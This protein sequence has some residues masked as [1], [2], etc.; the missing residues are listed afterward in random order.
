LFLICS[1]LQ[2]EGTKN[3]IREFHLSPPGK[4]GVSCDADGAFIGAMPIL[5]RLRKNGRDEWH[6]RDCQVLSKQIGAHYGLPIDMSSKAPGLRAIAN[7]LNDGDVVRA[8][9]A[10][11]LLGIPDLPPIPGRMG[12][13]DQM[14]KLIRDLD[15]SGMI[16]WDSDEHPRWPAGS[17]DSEGGD[18]APKGEDW[19]DPIAESLRTAV[20]EAAR[21]RDLEAPSLQRHFEQKYDN[22][23]PADFSNQV[24]QFGNW[25]E[26]HGRS[27]SPAARQHALA[28][29]D[30]VQAR[31]SFWQAYEYKPPAAEQWMI[32]A[33]DLLYQG[34]INGG[35]EEAGHIPPSMVA[36]FGAA[37]GLDGGQPHIPTARM[38]GLRPTVP[39]EF[40]EEIEGHGFTARND[41]VGINWGYRAKEQGRNW[42]V[43]GVQ[44][45]PRAAKLP[46]GA[47][48]FDRFDSSSGEAIS[49]KTL[50]TQ[51]FSTIQNPKQIYNRLQGYLNA[52]AGYSKPR[53]SFDLDPAQIKS[54]T[55]QLA[56][57]EY[58]SP[59]Q[60]RQ[61]HRAILFGRNKGVRVVITRI[62]E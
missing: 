46:N 13:R 59:A 19:H 4:G 48:A 39:S 25:L 9:I 24:A 16:K 40:L 45:N 28:E 50:N 55:L 35:I 42:E 44:Q 62:R 51:T 53:T 49:D 1:F 54:K 36:V 11:V 41:D 21:E 3:L 10:T 14:I 26:R 47:K 61:L 17:P 60:W 58:T 38:P 34:A 31:L 37:W 8:Q 23:G 57:P 2:A 30:F 7:A 43:Y 22:L 29:Y 52:V 33:A 20:A 27:L 18:F 12:S 15:W 6:P 56:I 32:S 5:E